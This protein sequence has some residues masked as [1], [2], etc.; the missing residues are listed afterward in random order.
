MA[1]QSDKKTVKKPTPIVTL[2]LQLM[3]GSRPRHT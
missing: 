3:G 1:A 2:D